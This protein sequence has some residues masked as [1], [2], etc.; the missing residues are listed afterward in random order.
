M[1]DGRPGPWASPT[2]RSERAVLDDADDGTL[3]AVEDDEEEL[4]VPRAHV[5]LA[6]R[7]AASG[8][9]EK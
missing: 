3:G 9:K 6:S 8:N 1:P 7:L 4:E 5:R 2:R